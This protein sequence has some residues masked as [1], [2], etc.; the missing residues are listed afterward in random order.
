MN[1]L[2]WILKELLL[3]KL[4]NGVLKKLNFEID[5]NISKYIMYKIDFGF[6]LRARNSKL[7]STLIKLYC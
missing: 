1:I 3:L 6:Q 5:F 4:G 2:S 7:K